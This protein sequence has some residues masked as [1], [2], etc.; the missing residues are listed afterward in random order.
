MV[1]TAENTS[2]HRR[3]L[4]YLLLAIASVALLLWIGN[5]LWSTPAKFVPLDAK[6]KTALPLV[7]KPKPTP[8]KTA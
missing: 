3:M 4:C 6:P 8:Y 5:G 2:R 7:A 1:E